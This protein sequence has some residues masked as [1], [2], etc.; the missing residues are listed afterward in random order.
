MNRF[1]LGTAQFG[2][3]Y[4]IN[5]S[6]KVSLD[7]NEIEEI[8][9]FSSTNN[10]KFA[11]DLSLVCLLKLTLIFIKIKYNLYE[12]MLYRSKIIIFQWKKYYLEN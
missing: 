8:L 6:S 11:L 12:I 4:G 1:A 3:K 10:I 9:N 2:M 7:I 5:N